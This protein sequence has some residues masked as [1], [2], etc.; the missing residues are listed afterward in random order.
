MFLR[1]VPYARARGAVRGEEARLGSMLGQR[2]PY[3]RAGEEARR[4]ISMFL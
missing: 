4:G 1:R 3:V 2:V